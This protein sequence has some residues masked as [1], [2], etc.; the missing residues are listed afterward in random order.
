MVAYF[1][2]VQ[3]GLVSLVNQCDFIHEPYLFWNLAKV[4]NEANGGIFLE[5]IV[6][7]VDVD[8]AFIEEM[9]EDIDG[10]HCWWSLL[11]VPKDQINPLVDVCADVVTLQRLPVGTD[12]FPRV[13]LCPPGQD[14][15]TELH[16]TLLCT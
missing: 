9:V 2:P 12:E 15:I 10:L 6:Y 4:V 5:R 11:F 8:V 16:S 14:Y 1:L 3:L 13:S 7:G